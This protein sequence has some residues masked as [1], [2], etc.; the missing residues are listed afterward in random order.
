MMRVRLLID[1]MASDRDI[2]ELQRVLGEQPVTAVL[3]E[4]YPS[5]IQGR[6]MGATMVEKEEHNASTAG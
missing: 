4:G 5:A 6:F 3:V 2:N 1:V